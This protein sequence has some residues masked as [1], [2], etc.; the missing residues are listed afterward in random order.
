MYEI[1]ITFRDNAVET[2]KATSYPGLKTNVIVVRDIEKE[3]MD[4]MVFPYERI[5]N[6]MINKLY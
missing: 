2:Y 4:T 6:I 1:Q 5:S 3:E